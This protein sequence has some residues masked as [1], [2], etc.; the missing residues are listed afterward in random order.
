MHDI[1]ER[2]LEDYLDGSPSR[3]FESHLAECAECLEQAER[4]RRLNAGFRSLRVDSAV[5]PPLGFSARVMRGLQE[6]QSRSFWNVFRIDASLVRKAAVV[7]LLGLAAFGS[8]LATAPG[9]SMAAADHT[10]EAVIAS[11]DVTAADPQ[12]HINGMLVTLANY[13]QQ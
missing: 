6:Q 9:D 2:G 8:Y 1:I 10:P 3:E 4:M 13:H 12:Q 5:G 11:H 7:S